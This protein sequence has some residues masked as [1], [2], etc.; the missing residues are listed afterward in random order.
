MSDEVGAFLAHNGV[1]GMHWGVRKSK[2][3]SSTHINIVNPTTGR[4]AKIHYDSNKASIS[5]HPDGSVRITTNSKSHLKKIQD[6]IDKATPKLMSD[7]E[8]KSRVNR[9][10]LEK[11]YSQATG[12]KSTSRGKKIATGALKTGAGIGGNVAKQVVTQRLT[13]AVND[14]ID[15][16]LK[17]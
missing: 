7:E 1:K 10:N 16:Q 4:S 17:K 12:H 3:S 6:Q 11:Q 14:A 9:I 15:S 13:K 2:S 5:Q 8:L